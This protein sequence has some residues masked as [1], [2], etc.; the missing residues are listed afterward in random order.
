MSARRQH[1]AGDGSIGDY[2]MSLP[3]LV[4]A[5]VTFVAAA[6]QAV[7]GFGF[8]VV[9]APFF[10]ASLGITSGLQ[11]TALLS[12]AFSIAVVW[13]RRRD[14]DRDLLYRLVPISFL[15]VAIGSLILLHL[16]KQALLPIM[17]CLIL[18]FSAALVGERIWLRVTTGHPLQPSVTLE[19]L[20]GCTAG[21]A[22]AL[23][24]MP[25]PPV[26][27]YLLLLRQ[28]NNLV[29]ATL[30]GFFVPCYALVVAIAIVREGIAAWIWLTALALL[31][32]GAIGIRIGEWIAPR[33]NPLM[34]FVL[35]IGLLVCAGLYASRSW[36]FG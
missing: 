12:G 29:R 33:V 13:R 36:V 24:A 7:T 16:P 22:T 4:L 25:G 6:A 15:G 27:I 14:V 23:V 3:W 8:A 28:Q 10:V 9:A 31:A 1:S 19:Y 5:L 17:G 2:S 11:L 20:L 35:A 32:V 30:A 26:L 34:F 18:L 21:A